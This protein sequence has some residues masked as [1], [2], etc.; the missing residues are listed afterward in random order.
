MRG[1][2]QAELMTSRVPVI[3]T[4]TMDKED[5]WSARQCASRTDD[6]KSEQA[7]VMTSSEQGEVMA[8]S[9]QARLPVIE[10]MTMDKDI[11]KTIYE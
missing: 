9:E 10:T 8:S 11:L 6:F 3:E 1:N 7:E 2:E 4:F 5:C